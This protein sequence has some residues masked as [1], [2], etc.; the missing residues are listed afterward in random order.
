MKRA[1]VLLQKSRLIKRVELE[2]QER[3]G[4]FPED[5]MSHISTSV[6]KHVDEYSLIFV[7]LYFYAITM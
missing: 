5:E 4:L 3:D 2:V 7:H 6:L 1:L